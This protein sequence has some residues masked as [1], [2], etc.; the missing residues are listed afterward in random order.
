MTN[1]DPKIK[2]KFAEIQSEKVKNLC[3]GVMD[4]IHNTVIM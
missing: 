4:K 2:G 3:I 1:F